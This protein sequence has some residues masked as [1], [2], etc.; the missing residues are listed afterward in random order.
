MPLAEPGEVAQDRDGCRKLITRVTRGRLRLDETWEM[1]H[2]RR[3]DYEPLMHRSSWSVNVTTSVFMDSQLGLSMSRPVCSWTVSLGTSV[4]VVHTTLQSEYHRCG[5]MSVCHIAMALCMFIV[6]TLASVAVVQA[7]CGTGPRGISSCAGRPDGKYQHCDSCKVY[8]VCRGGVVDQ[9]CAC[10]ADRVWVDTAKECGWWSG[11]CRWT[12][13]HAHLVNCAGPAGQGG[14]QG[15]KPITCITFDSLTWN[16]KIA[17][18]YG[19]HLDNFG[20]VVQPDCGVDGS[21]GRFTP[22]SHLQLP[23]FRNNDFFKLSLSLWFKRT[24]GAGE[25]P[26]LVS[27]GK[28]EESNI[29]ITSLSDTTLWI[30]VKGTTEQLA[31]TI[32]TPSQ[33][34][35]FHHMVVTFYADRTTEASRARIYFDGQRIASGTIQG[36][37]PPVSYPMMIGAAECPVGKFNYFT[38]LMDSISFAQTE[39]SADDVTRLFQSNGKCIDD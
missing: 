29:V 33:S 36:K 1:S 22:P 16:G 4:W 34:D 15:L 32:T 14:V 20:V 13:K 31:G 38:G 17:A 24:D 37:M 27:N 39:L 30:K 11:V 26:V 35:S 2:R 12:G 23:Y 7:G 19:V 10:P 18:S 8:V 3:L 6:V 21:C 28:C 25:F 9:V 5:K